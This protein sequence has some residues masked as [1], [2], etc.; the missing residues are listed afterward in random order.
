MQASKRECLGEKEPDCENKWNSHVTKFSSHYNKVHCTKTTF[1]MEENQTKS[2]TLKARKNNTFRL[3]YNFFCGDQFEP[4]IHLSRRWCWMNIFVRA[5]TYWLN[6]WELH[7]LWISTLS[8]WLHVPV[9]WSR[10]AT[11]LQCV[12]VPQKNTK[13]AS[14]V[15]LRQVVNCFNLARPCPCANCGV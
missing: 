8:K 6:I 9:W 13:L 2:S 15:R 1:D 12:L 10:F 7:G 3:D 14:P 4:I 5:V 11:E